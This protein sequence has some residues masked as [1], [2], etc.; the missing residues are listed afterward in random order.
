MA[1]SLNKTQLIGRLGQDPKLSF[2]TS[3][4]P[5]AQASLATDE[6]YKNKDGQKIEATEWH[7]LTFWGESAKLAGERLKKG[8]LIYVE[9]KLKTRKWQGND[10]QDRYTTEVHVQRFLF[11]ESRGN[12]VP[13]PGEQDAPPS[14][15][16]RSASQDNECGPAFPSEASGMDDV[17][18]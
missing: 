13:P 6:S 12:G 9:G 16:G 1:G 14:R 10:G 11:L 8:A 15:Q 4:Q 18:F 7:R 5:V 2:L 17:P 3:G